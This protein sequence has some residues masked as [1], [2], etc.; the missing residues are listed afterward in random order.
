ML[1]WSEEANKLSQ[2]YPNMFNSK[3][4]M[5]SENTQFQIANS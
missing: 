5:V 3:T 1:V 4:I 2:P